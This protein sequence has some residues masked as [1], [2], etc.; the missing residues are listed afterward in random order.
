MAE[1][2]NRH[3]R[4]DIPCRISVEQSDEHFHAHVEL[5]EDVGIRPGDK[6]R[7]HGAPIQI[8]FGETAQFERMATVTRAGP[9]MREWTKLVAYL[10]LRELYEVSFSAGSL[11]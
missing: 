2:T 4:F 1:T 10:D 5:A 3:R 7:V 8:A 11:K 6:V 9:L